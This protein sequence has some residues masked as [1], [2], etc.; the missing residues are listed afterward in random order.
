M[1]LNVD[2]R[3]Y[4]MIATK[5][6]IRILSTTLI[7]AEFMSTWYSN[8]EAGRQAFDTFPLR[9]SVRIQIQIQTIDVLA[10]KKDPPQHAAESV[11]SHPSL[12]KGIVIDIPC[13]QYNRWILNSSGKNSSPSLFTFGCWPQIFVERSSFNPLPH[14]SDLNSKLKNQDTLHIQLFNEIRPKSIHSIIAI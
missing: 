9:W 8:V 6:P 10:V 1:Q 2:R 4:W 11:Q 12:A 3:C 14:H 5:P 7:L 13:I